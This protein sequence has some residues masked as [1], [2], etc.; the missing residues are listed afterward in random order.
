MNLAHIPH[1][2]GLGYICDGDS[3]DLLA[4]LIDDIHRDFV[5][6]TYAVFSHL[7]VRICIAFCDSRFQL[8][9]IDSIGIRRTCCYAGNLALLINSNFS[10][11][12]GVA[13]LHINGG[14]FT[15]HHS[16]YS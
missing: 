16:C 4:S 3:V 9:Y 1:I 11:D 2:A 14:A 6:R 12:D 13:I 15:I 8:R 7:D 5:A 10:I